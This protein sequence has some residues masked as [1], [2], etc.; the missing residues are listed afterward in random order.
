[1]ING[2]KNL[3]HVDVQPRRR[4]VPR[5]HLRKTVLRNFY[6]T[7]SRDERFEFCRRA[8][9]SGGYLSQIYGGWTLASVAVS[10]RIEAA[11]G[12]VI[13]AAYLRPDVFTQPKK[14]SN[15]LEQTSCR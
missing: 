6:I 7:L 12:G 8:L 5:P 1:M 4:R 9:T 14:D 3:Q 11:S 10:L 15:E 13:R 2:R